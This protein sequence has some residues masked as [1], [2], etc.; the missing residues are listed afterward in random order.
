MTLPFE[1]CAPGRERAGL[2]RRA[3]L[4]GT[5]A[6]AVAAAMPAAQIA[7]AVAKVAK[8]A[9]P[10]WIVGTPGEWDGEVIRAATREAAIRLRCEE[11]EFEDSPDADPASG[12][13]GPEC[14]CEAC[15]EGRGYEATRV[16]E[17]DGRPVDT[18]GG[19]DWLD[20]GREAI[21]D[22]CN[23][24]TS[25]DAGGHNIG[26]KAVCEDCMTLA[27]WDIVDPERAA[28]LR[29]EQEDEPLPESQNEGEA[30]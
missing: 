13:G 27:D 6:V 7:P 30:R 19:G 14:E 8:P 1:T 18:I 22:R 28:E 25:E 15:Y 5:S 20:V 23:Y 4:L 21:C 24:E 29:A 9:L 2:S 3:L 11:C 17:W 16:A 26:G 10:T 12:E